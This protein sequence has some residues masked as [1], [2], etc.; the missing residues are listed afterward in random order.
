MPTV[1]VYNISKE[2]VGE[3]TLNEAIFNRPVDPHCSTGW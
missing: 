2:K 1:S 3:L